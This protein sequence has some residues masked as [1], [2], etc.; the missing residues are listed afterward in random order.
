MF[1]FSLNEE[2]LTSEHILVEN[3][4]LSEIEIKSLESFDE[5]KQVFRVYQRIG[6]KRSPFIITNKIVLKVLDKSNINAIETLYNLKRVDK[7]WLGENV[8]ILSAPEGTEEKQ[9]LETANQIYESGLVEFAHPVFSMCNNELGGTNDDLYDSQW[10]LSKI[11]M[12]DAWDIT[13]GSSSV[14]IALIDAGVE[15][16]HPDLEDNLVQ[17]Y[18]VIDED[19][20]TEPY[21]YYHGTASA[22]VAAAVTNNDTGI[23]G[24][25]YNC[26][27]MPIQCIR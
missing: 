14:I 2:S 1:S 17:G 7:K 25:G 9:I 20:T 18:D 11:K 27:F 26:K 15:E 16:D 5:V 3:E 19:N 13:T 4:K 23:A 10:N 8:Y 6:K 22:G 21:G 12:S 24:V